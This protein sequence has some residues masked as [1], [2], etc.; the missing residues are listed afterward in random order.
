MLDIK[1]SVSEV[2]RIYNELNTLFDVDISHYAFSFKMRKIILLM[3]SENIFSVEDFIYHIRHSGSAKSEFIKSLFVSQSELFRDAELWN[4]LY[5]KNLLKLLSKKEVKI[6]I[7]Y[8]ITGEELYTLMFFS[9]LYQSAHISILVSHPFPENKGIISNRIFTLKDLKV[10]QKNIEILKFVMNTEDV[11]IGHANQLKINHFYGGD[12]LFE[13][14]VIENQQHISEFD[15][16]LYR[17]QLIY[18]NEE[19]QE[20]V[21]RKLSASLKNGGLLIIGE[22]ET[23]GQV[24]GKFKKVKS[25][26]SVYK[27]RIF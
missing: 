20:T 5:K 1:L 26:L 6:H 18:Y 4:F 27:K 15:M 14:N 10:C 8:C 3:Q 9:G 19:M 25:D 22:K 21:L 16:V 2:N 17:N 7:P 11:F 24:S 13:H 12:V 23:L